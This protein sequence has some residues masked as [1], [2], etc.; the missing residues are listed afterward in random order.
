MYKYI[1]VSSLKIG[2]N[3]K[4]LDTGNYWLIYSL[5]TAEIMDRWKN[6]WLSKSDNIE[7]SIKFYT[8]EVVKIVIYTL[9]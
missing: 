3:T 2:G 1:T 8:Y 6:T 9:F 5:A 4:C 7:L